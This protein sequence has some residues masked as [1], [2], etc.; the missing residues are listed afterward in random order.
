MTAESALVLTSGGFCLPRPPAAAALWAAWRGRAGSRNGLFS[1][2]F[3]AEVLQQPWLW[4]VSPGTGRVNAERPRWTQ[5]Q[6]EI[7][8][9][10]DQ[11]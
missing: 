9:Q 7:W 3:S 5:T 10:P 1:N 2:G 8:E 4:T 11:G 6:P